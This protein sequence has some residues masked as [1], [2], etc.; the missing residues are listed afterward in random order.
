MIFALTC[1]AF[2]LIGA[3]PTAFILVK[4]K[5]KKNLIEEGSGNIGARNTYEVTNSR[6]DGIVV[7]IFDFLKGL[8]PTFW[9]LEFS[10][11]EPELVLVTSSLLILGHNYSIFLKFKGGR[12]LATA[13]GIIIVI[14]FVLV[15]LW[16]AFFFFFERF[17]KNIH[18][19]TVAAL[20]V[21][22][23]AIL[24]FQTI[25]TEYNNPAIRLLNKN[26][27]FL[28]CTPVFLIIITKHIGPM[29]EIY[30]AR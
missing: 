17:I 19:S 27:L 13:A 10:G 12:G 21:L 25:V 7:L 28:I 3:I 11:F 5:H 23:V 30:K 29:I 6:L 8:V 22:L 18:I 20:I 16:I 9:F 24:L 15:F 4:F 14:N 2:Y 1:A 26:F